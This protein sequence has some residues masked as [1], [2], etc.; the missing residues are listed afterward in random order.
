[1]SKQICVKS[2]KGSLDMI[3]KMYNE[4]QTYLENIG[5]KR[6][7]LMSITDT[8]STSRSFMFSQD[9]ERVMIEYKK[10][11]HEEVLKLQ[12]S[13]ARIKFVYDILLMRINQL[14]SEQRDNV[15]VYN[16]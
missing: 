9:F 3:R 1:M 4:A 8:D 13:P 14:A 6:E 16:S 11:K 15:F 5:F 7:P 10:D 12:F 2:V